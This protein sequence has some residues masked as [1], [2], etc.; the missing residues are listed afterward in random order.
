MHHVPYATSM[1]YRK[2]CRFFSGPLFRHPEML[3]YDYYWRLD[4]TNVKFLCD[5]PDDPFV[6]MKVQRNMGRPHRAVR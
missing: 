1:S 4:S 3:K 5:I 6:F 2:M